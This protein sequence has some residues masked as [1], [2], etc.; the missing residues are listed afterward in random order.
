M[1]KTF[2]HELSGSVGVSTDVYWIHSWLPFWCQQYRNRIFPTSQ[3]L[4]VHRWHK[5]YSP[6]PL[7]RVIKESVFLKIGGT[8]K[9]RPSKRNESGNWHKSRKEWQQQTTKYLSKA[10]FLPFIPGYTTR[11]RADSCHWALT[12]RPIVTRAGPVSHS[13]VACTHCQ[14][15][16]HSSDRRHTALLKVHPS[17]PAVSVGS[18][19]GHCES[20][21]EK[22]ER[23]TRRRTVQICNIVDCFQVRAENRAPTVKGVLWDF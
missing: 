16:H 3:G 17:A 5:L 10:V 6:C 22:S 23:K 2:V 20:Q 9:G 13:K 12:Y 14:A 18:P 11:L 4:N 1:N 8:T 21:R 19:A 7:Y 15:A